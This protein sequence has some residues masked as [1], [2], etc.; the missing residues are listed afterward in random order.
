VLISVMSR[1]YLEPYGTPAGQTVLV[2]TGAAFAA[3]CVLLDRM[4]RI[5]LPERFTPRQRTSPP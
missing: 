2:V 4:S 5:E 3:G 1:P